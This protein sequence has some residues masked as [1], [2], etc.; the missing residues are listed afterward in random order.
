M[1]ALNQNGG[2]YNSGCSYDAL[3]HKNIVWTYLE[4]LNFR[5]TAGRQNVSDHCVRDCVQQFLNHGH[6]DALPKG[7]RAPKCDDA[8]TIMLL[9]FV[10]LFPKAYLDEYQTML[11]FHLN[12]QPHEVPS[13]S[14]ISRKLKECGIS[15]KMLSKIYAERYSPANLQNR[16][17]FVQ[18]RALQQPHQMYFL[19]E[20]GICERDGNRTHGWSFVGE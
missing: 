7:H 11:M 8:V 16:Y 10:R 5:E 9:L 19:D 17:A 15:M 6:F 3:K 12:L 1:A 14:A 13:M 4:T 2:W 18:W 20:T